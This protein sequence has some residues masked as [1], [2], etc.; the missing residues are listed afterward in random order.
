M[1]G[2]RRYRGGRGVYSGATVV[3][4]RVQA[5]KEGLGVH[6]GATIAGGRAQAFK[7]EGRRSVAMAVGGMVH[8][9]KAK[10]GGGDVNT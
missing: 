5:L 1:V 7:W 3:K 2:C 8:A 10:G 9:I 6:S 4:G